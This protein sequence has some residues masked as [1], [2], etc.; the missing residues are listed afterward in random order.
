MHDAT[1][2][3]SAVGSA[4]AQPAACCNHLQ[5]RRPARQLGRGERRAGQGRGRRSAGAAGA[6]PDCHRGEKAE[7]AP[8]QHDGNSSPH[9][10]AHL[11]ARQQ[12]VGAASTVQACNKGALVV[13][14]PKSCQLSY[15]SDSNPQLLALID[16]VP[17][18]LWGARLA[19]Q[20]SLSHGSWLRTPVAHTALQHVLPSRRLSP[21]RRKR[22]AHSS[23]TAFLSLFTRLAAACGA[24]DRRQRPLC[25]LH[26]APT[27]RLRGRAN[28]LFAGSH[29]GAAAVPAR[30]GTG[31]LH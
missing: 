18:E 10:Q 28:L 1:S 30:V 15:G 4:R 24:A 11:S 27:C 8:D 6:R 13:K 5:Q 3:S 26:P 7:A 22:R 14:L 25:A 31:D 17:P 20:V 2:T 21:A 19:L 16:R 12:N 23:R 29:Q 9:G